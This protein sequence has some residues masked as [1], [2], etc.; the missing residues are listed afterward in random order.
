MQKAVLNCKV[1]L[2]RLFAFNCSWACIYSCGWVYLN[3]LIG[4]CQGTSECRT[5]LAA[6]SFQI[7][8]SKG[9]GPLHRKCF[10]LAVQ[11]ENT[12]RPKLSW[13]CSLRSGVLWWKAFPFREKTLSTSS[14]CFWC[15]KLLSRLCVT[16]MAPCLQICRFVLSLTAELF[17][18]SSTINPENFSRLI[19]SGLL[20][21]LPLAAVSYRSVGWHDS[22]SSVEFLC[23][24]I[25]RIVVCP[26]GLQHHI[27]YSETGASCWSAE[28]LRVL[29]YGTP[30][31]STVNPQPQWKH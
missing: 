27:W 31:Y 11:V 19:C 14:M 29:K 23:V 6:A 1:F 13:I 10:Y 15:G 30:S 3:T 24:C 12:A 2:F 28:Q 9:S 5:G 17:F 4:Y 7:C 20:F 26:S 8:I 25:W 22:H 16:C 21:Y 18:F